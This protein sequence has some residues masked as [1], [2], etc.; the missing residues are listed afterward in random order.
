[1]DPTY[2]HI[3]SFSSLRINGVFSFSAISKAIH[4]L[5]FGFLKTKKKKRV[6]KEDASWWGWEPRS[7][8]DTAKIQTMDRKMTEKYYKDILLSKPSVCLTDQ[9]L[10][11]PLLNHLF[12]TLILPPF[13]SL[14]ECSIWDLKAQVSLKSTVFKKSKCEKRERER[15]RELKAQTL[16]SIVAKHMLD[17]T[18]T[19][20]HP[21][22]K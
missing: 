8:A 22:C 3:H 2:I 5:R 18:Q 11:H 19:F 20:S 12:F 14:N 13:R 10:W 4:Y 7:I 1:M 17:H 6:A 9:H 21:K 15:E 16:K